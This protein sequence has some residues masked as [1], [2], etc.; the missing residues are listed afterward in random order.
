MY[1]KSQVKLTAMLWLSEIVV[2]RTFTLGGVDMC[3]RLFVGHCCVNVFTCVL[4][5]RDWSQP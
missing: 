3:A 5:F 1:C 2:D 4:N